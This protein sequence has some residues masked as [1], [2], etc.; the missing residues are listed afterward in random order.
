MICLYGHQHVGAVPFNAYNP[1]QLIAR[2]SRLYDLAYRLMRGFDL[3]AF[4]FIPDI[5]KICSSHITSRAAIQYRNTVP[6]VTVCA[7]GIRQFDNFRARLVAAD[8]SGSGRSAFAQPEPRSGIR[9][10]LVYL[11]RN[12][13]HGSLPVKI[14]DQRR[15]AYRC[16]GL[17]NCARRNI[18]PS[19]PGIQWVHH[20][21]RERAARLF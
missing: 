17:D 20:P 11:A 14:I 1:E 8:T 7:A 6:T 18:C 19:P 13:L 4:R 2:L 3:N 10:H 5:G 15:F 9:A 12:R 16:R 21:E